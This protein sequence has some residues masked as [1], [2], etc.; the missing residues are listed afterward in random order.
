MDFLAPAGKRALGDAR[1]DVLS[2]V[3]ENGKKKM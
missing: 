3:Q 2:Q 1:R